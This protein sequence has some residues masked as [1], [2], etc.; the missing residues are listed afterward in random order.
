[1]RLENNYIFLSKE[2]QKSGG[3]D[4]KNNTVVL[5]MGFNSVFSRL[6]GNIHRSQQQSNLLR[7]VFTVDVDDNTC[8]ALI[9]TYVVEKNAYLNLTVNAPTQ[10][11]A[12]PLPCAAA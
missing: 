6:F 1:M 4:N 12:P 9:T 10:A 8:S 7:T 3:N 2:I 11:K 5:G